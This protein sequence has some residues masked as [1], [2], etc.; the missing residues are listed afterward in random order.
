MKKSMH[1]LSTRLSFAIAVA[2]SAHAV[3]DIKIGVGAPFTGPNAAF[4]DQIWRGAAQAAADINASGGVNGEKIVLVKGDDACEPKQAVAAANQM[5]NVEHV[6]GV[7]AHY[8][9]SSAIPA[10]EIYDEAQ[11]IAITPAASSPKLTERGLP[12]VFR[13][14]GRDD[15]Q[16]QVAADYIAQKLKAKSVAVIHD[17]DTFGQGVADTTLL[18]LKNQGVQAVVYEGLTR[19]EKDFN[20]VVTKIRSSKAEVVYF[21]GCHPEAGPLVRQMREQGLTIPFVTTDCTVTDQLVATAGGKQYTKGVLMT[22]YPDPRKLASGKDVVAKFRAE[23]YE[24]ESYTLFSYAS[25]QALAAAFKGAGTT[26]GTQ[27]SEWLK[28]HSV[29]TV[30]G[31]KSFTAQGDLKDSPYVMYEWDADGHYS[32]L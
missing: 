30:L 14:S 22:F 31:S 13:M 1:T 10:T 5:V 18:A 3:A 15:Q 23:G 12:G 6:V 32:Q 17:K 20:A 11:I 24:P 19:G 25:V 7:I 2:F 28:S 29:D 21:G 9:S 27:A 4:G 16:G 8:C 26:D